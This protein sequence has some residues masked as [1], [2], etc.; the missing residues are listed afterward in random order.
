MKRDQFAVIANIDGTFYLL[1]IPAIE[2]GTGEDQFKALV[3]CCEEYD[4]KD[5]VKGIC[6]DTMASNTSTKS[7]TNVRFSKYEGSIM[8][9]LACRRHVMELHCKH[10]WENVS[11]AKTSGPDNPVFKRYQ[12]SWNDIKSKFDVSLLEKL[13]WQ[14]NK[15]QDFKNKINK[16]ISFCKQILE[17][18]TTKNWSNYL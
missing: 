16:T 14:E 6:F 1:A 17:N 11:A 15:S 13:D 9:E 4:L 8:I 5:K 7:G 3:E 2:S 18:E 10:F 12:Q